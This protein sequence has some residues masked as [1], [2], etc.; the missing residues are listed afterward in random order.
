MALPLFQHHRHHHLSYHHRH[1]TRSSKMLGFHCHH[2]IHQ[3]DIT[4]TQITIQFHWCCASSAIPPP[5]PGPPIHHHHHQPHGANSITLFITIST[6][7]RRSSTITTIGYHLHLVPP[8]P[9]THWQNIQ[10]HQH[11]L[12]VAKWNYV[13]PSYLRC[14]L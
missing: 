4:T 7:L 13:K 8:A 14:Q 6:S 12:L 10:L 11:L 5:P 3:Q 2:Y 9:L 1:L